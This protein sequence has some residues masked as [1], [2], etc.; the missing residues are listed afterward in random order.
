MTKLHQVFI[1]AAGRG[2]RMMPLT[3]I[4]PK[5]LI[6]VKQKPLLLKKNYCQRAL[7]GRAN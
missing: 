5:P 3:A 1:F 6:E 4:T 2:E 7:F